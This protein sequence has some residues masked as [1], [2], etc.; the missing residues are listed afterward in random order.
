MKLFTL[1]MP[2]LES[3]AGS[4][5]VIQHLKLCWEGQAKGMSY[6]GKQAPYQFLPHL[7]RGKPEKCRILSWCSTHPVTCLGE[8]CFCYESIEAKAGTSL[9]VLR[10]MVEP[11]PWD[12][13]EIQQDAAEGCLRRLGG[14]SSHWSEET[15]FSSGLSQ[16]GRILLFTVSLGQN[17]C[18]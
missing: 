14:F 7:R 6:S 15:R 16:V 17:V 3:S 2:P 4:P 12:G 13:R 10:H 1:P 9:A 18:G 8:R 5:A 11:A